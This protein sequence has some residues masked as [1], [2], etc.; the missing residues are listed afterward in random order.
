M[1][2]DEAEDIMKKA[3]ELQH[4][5]RRLAALQDLINDC[6]CKDISLD[7]RTTSEIKCYLA[8]RPCGWFLG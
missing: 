1:T 2:R 5:E 8:A 4:L 6:L 7:A 3:E